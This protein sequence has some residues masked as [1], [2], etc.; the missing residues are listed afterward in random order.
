M[1]SEVTYLLEKRQAETQ[2]KDG[3]MGVQREYRKTQE[4]TFLTINEPHATTSRTKTADMLG[5][6]VGKDIKNTCE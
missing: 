3:V 6:G 4:G 5:G 2:R 1:L